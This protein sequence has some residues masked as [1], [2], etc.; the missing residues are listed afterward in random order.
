[1]TEYCSSRLK[2][3]AISIRAPIF[4][5]LWVIVEKQSGKRREIQKT[6]ILHPVVENLRT[7]ITKFCIYYQEFYVPGWS[8][9]R[10]RDEKKDIENKSEKWGK[11]PVGPLRTI[12]DAR[13][14]NRGKKEVMIKIENRRSQLGDLHQVL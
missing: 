14:A 9:V 3:N 12:K 6:Q 4:E 11:C 10:V 1:M 5:I 13:I 2:T 7:F 8:H